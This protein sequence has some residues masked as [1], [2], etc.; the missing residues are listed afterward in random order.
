MTLWYLIGAVIVLGIAILAVI[1]VSGGPASALLTWAGRFLPGIAAL[2]ACVAYCIA[3][4]RARLGILAPVFFCVPV[5][6]LIALMLW[7]YFVSV[8]NSNFYTMLLTIY[9]LLTLFPAMAL[10]HLAT[11][12]K[13]KAR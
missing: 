3:A 9:P 5:A 10:W 2:I 8:R 4:G 6:A 7:P 1:G 12:L 11:A 13:R